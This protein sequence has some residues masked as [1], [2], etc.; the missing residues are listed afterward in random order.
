MNEENEAQQDEER[1]RRSLR[2]AVIIFA[3][4]EALVLVPVVLYLIFR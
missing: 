3:V 1:S 4:V 2:N